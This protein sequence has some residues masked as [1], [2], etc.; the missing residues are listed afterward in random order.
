MLP[1]TEVASLNFPNA[2]KTMHPVST[3]EEENNQAQT[4]RSRRGNRAQAQILPLAWPALEV[5]T[6][7]SSE[8][9][10]SRHW[11]SHRSTSCKNDL[12]SSHQISWGCWVWAALLRQQLTDSLPGVA[13]TSLACCTWHFPQQLCLLNTKSEPTTLKNSPLLWRWDCLACLATN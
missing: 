10:K 5:H 1:F 4:E 13:A 8:H 9:T 6:D 2:Y 11:K 7:R 3:S 12:V